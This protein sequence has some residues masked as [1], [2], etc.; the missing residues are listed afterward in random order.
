MRIF[1]SS[2]YEDL[3]EYRQ[4]VRK[5]IEK[6]GHTFVGMEIFGCYGKYPL[7]K[8]LR[9]MNTCD[10]FIGLYAHS[11][12]SKPIN[13]DKSFIEIEFY[14]AKNK[15][16][17]ETLLYV[18][19]EEQRWVPKFIKNERKLKAFLHKILPTVVYQRFSTPE[20]LCT[21][22]GIDIARRTSDKTNT[23]VI[24]QALP[25]LPFEF[26]PHLLQNH[27]TGRSKEIDLLNKWF[28]RSAES[29]YILR[30]FGGMGKSALA[31]VWKN[32]LNSQGIP[33]EGIFWWSF[34]ESK[35]FDFDKFLY[36]A[37]TYTSNGAITKNAAPA[38]RDAV[39]T[40]IT[41][42]RKKRFLIVLDG[43]E[44]ALRCNTICVDRKNYGNNNGTL[45]N[46]YRLC[47]DLNTVAFLQSCAVGMIS[48]VLITSRYSPKEL[49]G[50]AGVEESQLKGMDNEE[51]LDFLKKQGIKGPEPEMATVCKMY[52]YHPLS[53][54][55]L[56][57]ALVQD[58]H[59]HSH[60][61]YAP[62]VH[63][64]V[65]KNQRELFNFVYH[66]LPEKEQQLIS[67][68]SAFTSS[69]KLYLINAIFVS[70]KKQTRLYDTSPHLKEAI[71]K[72]V[73]RGLYQHDTQS[74]TYDFHPLI[75]QY[76]YEQLQNK[77]EV[78]KMYRNFLLKRKF[79]TKIKRLSDLVPAIELYH[80]TIKAELYDEAFKFF[81][82]SIHHA[83]YFHL[84]EYLRMIDLL[85]AFFPE[86]RSLPTFLKNTNNKI[87]VLTVLAN[88]YAL[89]GHPKHAIKLYKWCIKLSKTV[90]DLATVALGFV[91]I[92]YLQGNL[93]NLK[94]A[95]A[96]LQKSI[97]ITRTNKVIITDVVNHQAL[98]RIYAYCG[99][100]K[101]AE[102]ALNDAL[103][104]IK[105][106]KKISYRKRMYNAT[107]YNTSSINQTYSVIYVCKA[108]H[109]LM[110]NDIS[111]AEKDAKLAFKFVTKTRRTEFRH[112]RN[113][114]RA[115]WLLG[116]INCQKGNFVRAENHLQK[117]LKNVRRIELVE[118]EAPV[119]LALAKLRCHQSLSSKDNRIRNE[120]MQE[121][122]NLTQEALKI[123]DKCE[124]RLQ[125][126]EIHLFLSEYYL[127]RTETLLT[128]QVNDGIKDKASAIRN[129]S[130]HAVT[131]K[132]R[133][134]CEGPL[135][136]Y[137]SVYKKAEKLLSDIKLI[138][139]KEP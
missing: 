36:D 76:C 110:E 31:W 101:K 43:F 22:V 15:C 48:K 133:A 115:D 14:H 2:T 19:D 54:R 84:G 44:S 124:Y 86:G 92:A 41:L 102:K 38:P 83:A 66:A 106:N 62:R 125:Q 67:Q 64:S 73:D 16:K 136:C 132:N 28:T 117:A 107:P 89:S 11:I 70:D 24:P 71:D 114:I 35:N 108:I 98:A 121:S 139:D 109:E 46:D 113:I 61:R 23:I 116:A 91:D 74:D 123:A 49:E 134:Y 100:F 78:H 50:L 120:Y 33:I 34:V 72:L 7:D 40:L 96:T 20:D 104:I 63:S 8:A 80:H 25:P 3:K 129:A 85:Q 97:S 88:S 57:N 77:L 103:E 75:R 95:K 87:W 128:L 111:S 21:K 119:L 45:D 6:L 26:R 94:L 1:V 30:A 60:I 13:H 37:I 138:P 39:D 69:I 131:S 90:N 122:F 51:A 93:G 17:I 127:G 27:F 82:K 130:K 99:K 65:L 12:G 4:A 52:G 81:Q 42:L 56:S 68:L 32:Q 5:V 79:P 135:Y 118:L 59:Y 29:I 18:V 10:L 9:E 58:T 126:A 137:D 112:I 47:M 55:L 53:L 105:K